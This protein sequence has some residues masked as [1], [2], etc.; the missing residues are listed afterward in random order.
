MSSLIQPRKYDMYLPTHNSST[1]S[2]ALY[3][4]LFKLEF[5]QMTIIQLFS[6]ISLKIYQKFYNL[7]LSIEPFSTV[8]LI[9]LLS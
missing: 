5:L 9:S 1:Y 3:K 7:T 8:I 2:S 4:T 6:I